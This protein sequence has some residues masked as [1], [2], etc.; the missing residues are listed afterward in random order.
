M[1]NADKQTLAKVKDL[2]GTKKY[3]DFV[4]KL[5]KLAKDDKVMSLLGAGLTDGSV[6]DESFDTEVKYL[7]VSKMY[8]TQNEIDLEKS[9][10][11]A[12][13]GKYSTTDDMLKG[14][15]EIVAPVVVLATKGGKYAILDGHHRWSQ[16]YSMNSTAKI[17]CLIL[18][19]IDIKPQDMLKVL[20]IAIARDIKKVPTQDVK[21]V[22]LLK[23]SESDISKAV[24]EYISDKTLDLLVK[25]NHIEKADKDLASDYIIGNVNNMKKT[26]QPIKG[27][28]SRN[29]MPQTPEAKNSIKNAVDGSTNFK[30]KFTTNETRLYRF[31]D[32][33]N[34]SY[35]PNILTNEAVEYNTWYSPAK[36][37]TEIDITHMKYTNNDLSYAYSESTSKYYLVQSPNASAVITKIL[38]T[39]DDV[40]SMKQAFYKEKRKFIR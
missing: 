10:K 13:L 11:F 5:G 6:E 3:E 28:S 1:A 38:G 37:D 29:V 21:G 14:E 4:N 20:Q 35:N 36:N 15:V 23:A 22:N 39:F 16:V 33:V 17:K 31:N 2:M 25:Y 27:A 30:P 26:S 8:P 40:E 34:E 24:N 19:G 32:F 9:L 18:T 7:E 12:L